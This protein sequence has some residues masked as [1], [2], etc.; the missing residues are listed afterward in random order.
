MDISAILAN[1]IALKIAMGV[2]VL[3]VALSALQSILGILH[4]N[5]PTWL[6]P[7]MGGLKKVVDL[8]SANQPH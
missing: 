4:K 8:I 3:N 1:P 2:L 7:L 5:A 6:Q